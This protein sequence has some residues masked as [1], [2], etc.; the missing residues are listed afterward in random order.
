VSFPTFLPTGYYEVLGTT[1]G[2]DALII[3][4]LAL[5]AVVA[6][7]AL[8]RLTR[9]GA[10]T[11]AVVDDPVLLALTGTNPNAVR[12]VSWI[13]GMGFAAVSGILAAAAV[14]TLDPTLLT[15]LLISAFGAAAIG[16]FRSVGLAYAGG[17]A[18]GVAASVATKYVPGTSFVAGL[19]AS[20]PVI[21]LFVALLVIPR[22]HLAVTAARIRPKPRAKP[23]SK[24]VGV[25]L[26]VVTVVLF[27]LAPTLL[28][29][30]RLPALTASVVYAILLLSLI[31]LVQFS[32]QVSLCQYGFAAVGAAA[33]YRLSEKTGIPWIPAVLLS[34]LVAIPIGTLVAIPAARLSGVFLAVST[35]GFGVLLQGLFYSTDLM[36]GEAASVPAPRPGFASSDLGYYRLTLIVLAVCIGGIFL[37][38]GT[39]LG[40]LLR[41]MGQSPTTMVAHGTNLNVTK[42]L[43]FSLSAFL[44]GIA[45]ALY[46]PIAQSVAPSAFDPFLSLNLVALLMVVSVLHGG[47]VR[48]AILGGLVLGLVPSYFTSSTV[49][50]W[51]SVVFGLAA[52]QIAYKA[53]S[54]GRGHRPARKLPSW[55]SSGWARVVENEASEVR[56]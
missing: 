6:L 46:G 44:A 47:T 11:R 34:G 5:A 29:Q 20:L 27:A 43:V 54:E 12:R 16:A 55:R 36:F 45:G 42:V 50:D 52:I 9:L 31:L 22:R 30:A 56:A 28:G 10:S 32:G 7:T 35:F 8:L 14:G 40:R 1:I 38:N 19:P 25:A 15:L 49:N 18:V 17:L 41:G 4:G 37:I 33:F 23:L 26:T 21:V 13:I 3:F 53:A 39:R 24:G 48:P 2:T 51:L